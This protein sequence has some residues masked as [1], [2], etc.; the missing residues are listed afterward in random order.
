[1]KEDIIEAAGLIIDKQP[2]AF[3]KV[4]LNNTDHM[5]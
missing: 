2:N 5:Y 3:F 1:M 4:Q